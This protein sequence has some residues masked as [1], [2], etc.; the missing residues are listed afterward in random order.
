MAEF[1]IAPD[2]IWMRVR[3][4]VWVAVFMGVAMLVGNF[5]LE[6]GSFWSGLGIVLAAIVAG[7]VS[8]QWVERWWQKRRESMPANRK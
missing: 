4:A 3:L 2:D 8:Y 5:V 1:K 6:P 7:V